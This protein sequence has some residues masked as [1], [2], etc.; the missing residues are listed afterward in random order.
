MVNTMCCIKM[1]LVHSDGEL[2]DFPHPKKENGNTA[3][4]VI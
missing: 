3:L 1:Q 2:Q 4:K